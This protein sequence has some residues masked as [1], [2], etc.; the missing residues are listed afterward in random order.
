[1]HIFQ[2]SMIFDIKLVDAAASSSGVNH[3]EPVL[4]PLPIKPVTLEVSVIPT[5]EGLE[6]RDVNVELCIL[7][8]ILTN[9]THS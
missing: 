2:T 9:N 1:M 7:A 6:M 4:A 5:A 8:I 3:H